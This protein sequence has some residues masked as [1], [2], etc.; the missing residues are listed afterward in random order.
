MPVRVRA[1]EY[2]PMPHPAESINNVGE[3]ASAA[4]VEA[5]IARYTTAAERRI[6]PGLDTVC[7]QR[8]RLF[9]ELARVDQLNHVLEQ[10]AN[11]GSVEVETRVNIG[12]EIYATAQVDLG[13]PLVLDVGSG[14]F[15]EA[16]LEEARKILSERKQLLD[17][18]ANDATASIVSAQAHLKAVLSNV[19]RL[20]AT[21][22]ALVQQE[23]HDSQ[24][25]DDD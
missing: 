20:R 15:I 24:F 11:A 10:L 23:M 16:S 9:N 1:Q 19:A 21:H 14:I 13:H 25:L 6:K 4:E 18:L 5:A 17:E 22:A 3:R 8:D 12:E 7:E 2:E